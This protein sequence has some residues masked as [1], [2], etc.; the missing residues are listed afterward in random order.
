[1]ESSNNSRPPNV[2]LPPS[3]SQ[4]D[5]AQVPP[6]L[7]APFTPTPA[8]PSPAPQR[9]AARVPQVDFPYIPPA[10]RNDNANNSV[11]VNLSGPFSQVMDQVSA[12][13]NGG[14]NYSHPGP[15]DTPGLAR[16]NL[17]GAEALANL[18]HEPDKSGYICEIFR[19]DPAVYQGQELPAGVVDRC[20][21]MLYQEI[22]ERTRQLNGGGGYR[23][24]VMDDFGKQTLLIPFRIDTITDPP[25]LPQ[26]RQISAAGAAR[27][28]FGAQP[29]GEVDE[30]TALRNEERKLAAQE[31]VQ[32][33]RRQLERKQKQWSQE[34]EA[35]VERRE[36]RAMAP[37]V[38]M[39]NQ[40]QTL[41]RTMLQMQQ[42]AQQQMQALMQAS[43]QQMQSMMQVIAQ[44]NN[45]PP[46]TTMATIMVESMKASQQMMMGLMT[47]MFSQNGT[48]QQ[49]AI[50]AAKIQADANKQI[51]DM[52]MKSAQ[53]GNA[54]Y[55]KVIEAMMHNALNNKSDSVTQALTL[56]ETG[57]RQTMEMMEFREEMGGGRG[58][59]EFEWNE[60]AGVG[61]NLAKLIFST[62]KEMLKGGG[63]AAGLMQVL[64]MLKK[65]APEQ[66]TPQDLQR[67][68]V[69]LEQRGGLPNLLNRAQ[70]PAANP[71][72]IPGAAAFGPPPQRAV[73]IPVM[74]QH[75][76]QQHQAPQVARPDT[77][78]LPANTGIIQ[79]VFVV[80]TIA[81]PAPLSPAQRAQQQLTPH[82][83]EQP[84]E[85]VQAPPVQ[86]SP[87]QADRLRGWV[88]ES[89][90]TCLNED[91]EDG[92]REHGWPESA[93]AKWNKTFLDALVAAP[94]DAGRIRL[95]AEQCDPE[96][97]NKLYTKLLDERNPQNYTNF[98]NALHGL[99]QEH[100]Q[101]VGAV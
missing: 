101:L 19:T 71:Q 13:S 37:V 89:M 30:V 60:D 7:P 42:A 43:Q 33:K 14:S 9:R 6:P 51:M 92:L 80:E 86:I 31:S 93:L 59:D 83:V 72:P 28:M 57:R 97:W 95:I 36:Q 96:L 46:D 98:I 74:Q 10:P 3:D 68:A 16:R 40:M 4:D 87:A 11:K 73:P 50:E 41:E 63:G 39:Q 48:K 47:A 66:V 76:Q 85:E 18:V 15:L 29:S 24:K 12:L 8:P 84:V 45:K 69:N 94:D 88:T 81:A 82:P 55:D 23:L 34:E 78:Q 61:G 91:I 22:Y 62:L 70:I 99:V 77:S 54:R 90:D 32:E 64:S 44:G 67:L 53:G 1:M 52:A 25:K 20:P 27:A 75:V 35:D 5:I 21:P 100:A 38:S 26:A 17:S 79:E 49:E 56:I 2:D 65:Q 58:G